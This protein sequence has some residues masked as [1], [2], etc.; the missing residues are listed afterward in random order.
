MSVLNKHLALDIQLREVVAAVGVLAQKKGKTEAA[1]RC[2]R[3]ASAFDDSAR[4]TANLKVDML[5]CSLCD[6]MRAIGRADLVADVEAIIAACKD[7]Q[8]RQI[9]GSVDYGVSTIGELDAQLEA[10]HRVGEKIL[11]R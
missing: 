7:G 9:I 2:L 4:F 6:H 3:F 5:L 11:P 8:H 1:E 10:M